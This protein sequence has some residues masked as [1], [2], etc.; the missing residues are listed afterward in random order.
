[1][2]ILLVHNFYGSSAPSGE[3]R[4][5]LEERDLL[6]A[7][8]HEVV[9]YFTYSDAIRDRGV[10][11]VLG[12]AMFVPW[13]S[14][15]RKALRRLVLEIRPD[16]MHVHNVFP[17]L[18]PA[19]FGAASGV[20]TAVVNTLH[21]YRTV[22]PASL[23][24]RNGRACT[25]CIEARSVRP[26]LRHGCYRN[27]RLATLP[28]AAS[29]A[30]HRRAQT[31]VRYV[32]AFIAL[33]NFQKSVLAQGGLPKQHIYVKPNCYPE[34][35]QPV[36]WDERDDKA[37]FIGRIS[38]EKGVDTLVEAWRRLGAAA[39]KLEIIGDGPEADRLQRSTANG[40]RERVIF[41]GR[42][43]VDETRAHLSRAKLLIVPSTWFE[44]F[45]LVVCEAFAFG[46]P[47]AASQFG[48]FEEIVES[49]G[50]GRLFTAGDPANLFQTIA[51][52]WRDQA[53]LKQMGR[54]A[55][56]E[57]VRKYSA[58]KN[59]ETLQAIYES[60]LE[61]KRIRLSCATLERRAGSAELTLRRNDN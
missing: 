20:P 37:V 15:Q 19:I 52:L 9:E 4:A 44:A 5:V 25:D 6:R 10:L 45:P 23:P 46:V 38:A 33:T 7:A 12:A 31:Y 32:D 28:L 29:V 3:N 22:C 2:R 27:S 24:L 55:Y 18:S 54:L 51:A 60:A 13:N 59:V 34:T 30:I 14:A 49:P 56:D 48:T 17:L 58:Q 21:N 35:P 40:C 43:A 8:G 26:A 47:V 36:P 39:P 57:F 1:M 41:V 61:T 53:G 42:K 50:A 16:V 11:P